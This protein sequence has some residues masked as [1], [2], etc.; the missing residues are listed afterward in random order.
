MGLGVMGEITEQQQAVLSLGT[1][2][3]VCMRVFPRLAC[4]SASASLKMPT[5]HAQ[6]ASWARGATT[7]KSLAA[8]C[9][10]VSR[11]ILIQVASFSSPVLLL[12][13]SKLVHILKLRKDLSLPT[14]ILPSIGGIYPI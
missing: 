8:V 4:A 2:A 6:P 10:K 3:L 12:L 14:L 5:V 13:S 9:V 11:V 1:G 7:Q